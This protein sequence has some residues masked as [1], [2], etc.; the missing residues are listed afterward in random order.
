MRRFSP[1]IMKITS[2]K[3][4]KW[5]YVR[6]IFIV[7]GF[8]WILLVFSSI[9]LSS[10]NE[11]SQKAQIKREI[12]REIENPPF[13]HSILPV[14]NINRTLSNTYNLESVLDCLFQKIKKKRPKSSK[15]N[16]QQ[17]IKIINGV[18]FYKLND[19]SWLTSSFDKFYFCL[20]ITDFG[21]GN[22]LIQYFTVKIKLYI[23]F[24]IFFIYF[25][26]Y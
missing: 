23:L 6:V 4:S 10:T 2:P 24:F 26:I 3:T 20:T 22:G 14:T 19:F 18:S 11:K 5:S 17:Q 25:F 13:K 16:K 1:L 12:Q 15:S 8:F 7:C 9:F 21:F